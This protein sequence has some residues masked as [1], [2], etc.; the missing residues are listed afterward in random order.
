MTSDTYS[1]VHED[2]GRDRFT[3]APTLTFLG[4]AETVTGSRFLVESG[5]GHVLV[6]AGLYQ[7][8][9]S[10]R[11]RNQGSSSSATP[12]GSASPIP[13]RCSTFD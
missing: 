3:P 6:D 13:V 2:I 7:G 11:R 9:A 10:L 5:A 12:S 1:D 4:A 8:V